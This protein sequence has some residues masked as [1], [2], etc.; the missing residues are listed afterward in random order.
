MVLCDHE[1]CDTRRATSPPRD[2]FSASNNG[3]NM[4]EF[5]CT[6][7]QALDDTFGPNSPPKNKERL[8]CMS[9]EGVRQVFAPQAAINP[10]DVHNHHLLH[11]SDSPAVI[12]GACARDLVPPTVLTRGKSLDT[13]P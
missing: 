9:R 2:S 8:D 13:A 5:V 10:A 3:F 12:S 4:V 11:I 6:S 7:I 1:W